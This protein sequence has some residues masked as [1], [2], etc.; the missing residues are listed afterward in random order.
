M[1]VLVAGDKAR[2]TRASRHG[3]QA[4][5]W[6]QRRAGSSRRRARASPC[7]G[8]GGSV[9][10][11]TSVS[12]D[13][14]SSVRVGSPCAGWGG[15]H[16]TVLALTQEAAGEAL[17]EAEVRPVAV[18]GSRFLPAGDP[19]PPG[20]RSGCPGGP[21]GHPPTPAPAPAG[22]APVRAWRGR[23]LGV[24]RPRSGLSPAAL[25]RLQGPHR[26]R[27]LPL[28][29]PIPDTRLRAWRQQPPGVGPPAPA[30]APER[31]EPRHPR[32]RLGPHRDELAPWHGHGARLPPGSRSGCGTRC[33]SRARTRCAQPGA[34][35][36]SSVLQRSTG[37]P[38]ALQGTPWYSR[39]T[40]G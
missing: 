39:D 30:P 28:P 35:S 38:P 3:T 12:G 7:L 20:S 40:T 26:R 4:L 9:P 29:A 37:Q 11:S 10:H 1:A 18:P 22:A 34:S 24:P 25:S 6:G 27:R 5:G 17:G 36:C 14:E 31:S 13:R 8:S 16:G 15:G 21:H 23:G 19:N 32:E 2:R 33:G